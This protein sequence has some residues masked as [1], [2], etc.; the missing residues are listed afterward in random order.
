MEHPNVLVIGGGQAG[1]AVS[2]SLSLHGIDHL[3][4]ERGRIGESWR[5]RWD[6]LRLLTP[7]WLSRLPGQPLGAADPDGFMRRD[8]VVDQLQGYAALIGA[9][10]LEHTEVVSASTDGAGWEVRT[11]RGDYRATSLV[12]ATGHCQKSR[13]P[14]CAASLDRRIRQIGAD[15]YRSPEQLPDGGVLVVGASATGVQLA[16]ELALSGR[17][18]TLAAGTHTRLPRTYRGKDILFWLDRLGILDRRIDEM[19]DPRQAR[20]EPSLQ[21]VGR[22]DDALGD[23]DLAVLAELG[24]RIVGRL[25]GVDGT[26]VAL[27]DDL[28]EVIAAADLRLARLLDRIDHHL[29]AQQLESAFP[30]TARPRPIALPASAPPAALDLAHEGIEAV[31]WATGFRRTYPWLH[32]PALDA[33]GEIRHWRGRGALPGL[34]VLGLQFQNRRRSSF[35][36]GVGLDA[37][38]IAVDIARRTRRLAQAA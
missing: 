12:V 16:R 2:S 3:V 15:R 17:R 19:P 13:I 38:E 31:V 6:S 20:R 37:R 10:I 22:G 27:G 23:L 1:L 11:N 4:I 36:G 34:Y 35:L 7:N 33:A 26:S 14:G 8:Q 5:R 18:V 30:A 25:V 28:L 29:A 21:L 24:V 32:A 9:P